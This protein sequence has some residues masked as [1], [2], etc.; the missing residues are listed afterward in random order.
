MKLEGLIYEEETFRIIGACM[1]VH[2]EMG[3]GFLE[4]AYQEA[5]ELEFSVVQIPFESQK[6]IPVFYKEKK[7]KK[8]Y[9]ADFICF[10]NIIVEI[11]STLFMHQ[12]GKAQVVNYLK[13]TKFPVGLLIN[14]GENSLQWKRFINTKK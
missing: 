11:K 4:S 10:E 5:L 6:N 1:A 8:Y 13:A 14:F 7:L 2:N 3:C 12:M 9:K